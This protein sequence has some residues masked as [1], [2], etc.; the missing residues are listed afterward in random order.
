MSYVEFGPDD[1][2]VAPDTTVNLLVSVCFYLL[3]RDNLNPDEI[4][5]DIERVRQKNDHG[6]LSADNHQVGIIM[7]QLFLGRETQAVSLEE[8][9]TLLGD[10]GNRTRASQ[11]ITRMNQYLESI[12]S[13]YEL[14]RVSVYFFRRKAK[15]D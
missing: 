2:E 9:E 5:A 14:G 13:N 15:P 10:S 3:F 12:G 4:A 8:L 11:L 7:Q 6:R 1:F